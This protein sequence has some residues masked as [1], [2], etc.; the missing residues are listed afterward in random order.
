MLRHGTYG[1]LRMDLE[2]DPGCAATA[3]LV[4]MIRCLAV[5]KHEL[6]HPATAGAGMDDSSWRSR[7]THIDVRHAP[8]D[9]LRY[10]T[11]ALGQVH[12]I[13]HRRS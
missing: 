11:Y 12:Q 4:L 3:L 13:V 6:T 10:G 2:E 8:I 7:G 9:P 5:A 1:V